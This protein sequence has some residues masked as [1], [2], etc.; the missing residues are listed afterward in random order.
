MVNTSISMTTAETRCHFVIPDTQRANFA[1][2][3]VDSDESPVC[4]QISHMK[5][6]EYILWTS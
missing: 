6:S 1:R 5:S 4:M 2:P 3:V